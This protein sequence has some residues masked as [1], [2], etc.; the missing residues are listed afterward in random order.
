MRT[1]SVGEVRHDFSRILGWV[2]DGEEVAIT[3]HRK[4]VARLLPAADYKSPR[5]KMPDVLRRLNKVFGKKVI[6]D[7]AMKVL[8]NENR[9][10]Y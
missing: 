7:Q 4:T 5:A 3:K 8:L 9:G 1:A 2:A 10:I 6:S